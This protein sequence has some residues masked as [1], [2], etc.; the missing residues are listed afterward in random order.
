MNKWINKLRSTTS[1][2]SILSKKRTPDI[3]YSCISS[4]RHLQGILLGWNWRRR[5]I[6]L[7]WWLLCN[8]LKNLRRNTTRRWGFHRGSVVQICCFLQRSG[9]V[10]S[11]WRKKASLLRI[12]SRVWS[13]LLLDLSPSLKHLGHTRG[14]PSNLH[15]NTCRS[16]SSSRTT[17]SSTVSHHLKSSQTATSWP[18]SFS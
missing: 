1:T 5:T 4:I 9:R 3:A 17:P 13:S 8:M 7:L 14:Y 18:T 2:R 11:I 6:R 15:K 10:T 12:T 16:F